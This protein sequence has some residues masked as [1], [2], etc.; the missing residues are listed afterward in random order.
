MKTS[1]QVIEG[2]DVVVDCLDNLK[3]RF[4]QDIAAEIPLVSVVIV[5]TYGQITAIF[6]EDS[7]LALAI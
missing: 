1:I 7:G 3:T 5:G 4:V 2:A 6:P